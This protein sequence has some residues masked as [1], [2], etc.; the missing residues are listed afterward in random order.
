MPFHG[1]NTIKSLSPV[2]ITSRFRGQRT[3]QHGIIVR[4]ATN[5]LREFAGGNGLGERWY[6]SINC[7][8]VKPVRA[9]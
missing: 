6:W 5:L 3:S 1:C 8:A 4:I 7:S 2:T 9:T